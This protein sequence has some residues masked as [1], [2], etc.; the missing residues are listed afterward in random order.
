MCLR[1]PTGGGPDVTLSDDVRAGRAL[2]VPLVV[3]ST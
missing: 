1:I 3:A 2:M